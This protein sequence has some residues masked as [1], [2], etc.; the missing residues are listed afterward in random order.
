[1]ILRIF[2][3]IPEDFREKIVILPHPLFAEAA[4][5]SD[6]KLKRYMQFNVKYDWI[7][8]DT[9]VLIT[10][11]SSIAYDAFYRGCRVIFYWEELN[12]CLE[13]YG[14]NTKLMLNENNV[15][16]DICYNQ[17][18]LR[19]CFDHNYFHA[20]SHLYKER[21]RKIVEFDDNKNTDRLINSLKKEKII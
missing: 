19:E 15:Y 20:Q 1:M 14:Q 9:R 5:N 2:E 18:D 10:D 4:K 8:R 3:A 7:L 13:Q 16:G 6:F 11:Y 12:Y 17:N 21:Y